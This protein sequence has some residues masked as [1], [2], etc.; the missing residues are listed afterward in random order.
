MKI[1][2]SF[3]LLFVG[4]YDGKFYLWDLDSTGLLQSFSI[5]DDRNNI[6]TNRIMF[7]E[8]DQTIM[9]FTSESVYAVDLAAENVKERAKLWSDDAYSNPMTPGLLLSVSSIMRFL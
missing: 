2:I 8:D 5:T 9:A 4:T 6:L 7:I 3:Q 1:D